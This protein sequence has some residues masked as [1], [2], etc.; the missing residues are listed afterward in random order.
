MAAFSGALAGE[1]CSCGSDRAKEQTQV[2]GEHAPQELAPRG[3]R[4]SRAKQLHMPASSEGEMDELQRCQVGSANWQEM[5][6]GITSA[7]VE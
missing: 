1:P 7:L 2:K 4:P 5:L 3:Q 6:P